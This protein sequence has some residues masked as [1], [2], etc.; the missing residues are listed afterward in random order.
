MRANPAEHGRRVRPSS[1]NR[2]E[3]VR[4]YNRGND[5]RARAFAGNILRDRS[6]AAGNNGGPSDQIVGLAKPLQGLAE[7]SVGWTLVRNVSRI[8]QVKHYR[9]FEDALNQPLDCG[10]TKHHRFSLDQNKVRVL[11][12]R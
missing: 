3:D 2:S 8:I 10:R 6:I 11:R 5:T 7:W 4:I 1:R 12:G 9:P